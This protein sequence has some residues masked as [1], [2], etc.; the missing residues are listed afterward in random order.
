MPPADRNRDQRSSSE[1]SEGNPPRGDRGPRDPKREARE[2]GGGQRPTS[3]QRPAAPAPDSEYKPRS[4]AVVSPARTKMQK[5]WRRAVVWMPSLGNPHEKRCLMRYEARDARSA[6]KWTV[7]LPRQCWK[8]G[9]T[10]ELDP[11]RFDVD[12]KIFHQPVMVLTLAIA[13]SLMLLVMLSCAG[14]WLLGLLLAAA[15]LGGGAVILRLKSWVEEVQ[16]HTWSC[17]PHAAELEQPDMI[18]DDDTLNIFL[19][20]PELT[21]AANADLKDR[22]RGG[23]PVPGTDTRDPAPPASGPAIPA[24]KQPLVGGA[25]SR[26]ER[27]APPARAPRPAPPP[28]EELPPIKL[29]DDDDFG[30]PRKAQSPAQNP[31]SPSSAQS[32]PEKSIPLDDVDP[33]PGS[34]HDERPWFED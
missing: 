19:P 6:L 7:V 3:S 16:L 1:R 12:V 32:L 5:L 28:R 20:T 14:Q 31:Q 27:E 4:G 34:S 17:H 21:K 15:V 13:I 24:S 26:A 25:P 8:C 33:L 9:R 10:E 2:A 22:R 23:R 18:I 11:R 30:P 29:D